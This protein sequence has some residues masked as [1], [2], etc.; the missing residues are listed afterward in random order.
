MLLL[1]LTTCVYAKLVRAPQRANVAKGTTCKIDECCVVRARVQLNATVWVPLTTTTTMV[2]NNTHTLRESVRCCVLFRIG[3]YRCSRR[4]TAIARVR[5]ASWSTPKHTHLH[6]QVAVRVA[7]RACERICSDTIHGRDIGSVFF[8]IIMV[9]KLL[10]PLCRCV[11]RVVFR[12][13]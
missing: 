6:L 13:R 4:A 3:C 2:E 5:A 1:M 8:V 10:V 12:L 9:G 7:A 11:I